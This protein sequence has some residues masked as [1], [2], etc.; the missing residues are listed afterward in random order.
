M[1]ER[2][3]ENLSRV[4]GFSLA[5]LAGVCVRERGG[6]GGRE[7]VVSHGLM[8]GTC[9]VDACVRDRQIDVCVCVW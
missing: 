6:G 3:R 5:F 1:T 8:I 2:E 9:V 7:R 4:V